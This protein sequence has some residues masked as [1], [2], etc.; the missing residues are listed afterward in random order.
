MVSFKPFPIAQ[1]WLQNSRLHISRTSYFRAVDE[2]TEAIA[3]SLTALDE[4]KSRLH[5]QL[6]SMS[7]EEVRC[8]LWDPSN[9]DASVLTIGGS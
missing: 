9:R 3:Q 7:T 1:W 4:Q 8:T 5:E 6:A 2:T